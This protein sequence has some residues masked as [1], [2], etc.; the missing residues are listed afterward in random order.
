MLVPLLGVVFLLAAFAFD[1]PV[2]AA[3]VCPCFV[4][5]NSESFVGVGVLSS[6][7]VFLGIPGIISPSNY[8]PY[9]MGHSQGCIFISMRPG[10]R[11][12]LRVISM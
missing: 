6:L 8:V 5:S 1:Y 2:I 7:I 11:Y 9:S 10:S 12:I 3:F 4:L